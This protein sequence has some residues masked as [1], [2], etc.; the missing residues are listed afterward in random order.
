MSGQP[1][2]PE[3]ETVMDASARRPGRAKR[4]PVSERLKARV[5]GWYRPQLQWAGTMLAFA[6]FAVLIAYLRPAGRPGPWAW[7]AAPLGILMA[8]GVEY[9]THRFPMHKRSK[10]LDRFFRR[11]TLLHHRYF[12]HTHLEMNSRR[13]GYFV[14]ANLH[15]ASVA[16][17]LM[18]GAYFAMRGLVGVHF[19]SVATLAMVGYGMFAETMHVAYHM[20]EARQRSWPLRSRAFQYLRELHR[21]HHNPKAMTTYNFA[22]G[23]PIWDLICGTYRPPENTEPT[24]EVIAATSHGDL[25]L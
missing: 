18:L 21:D 16:V 9:V 15:V 3:M 4:D 11:H 20:S 22:I 6:A 10:T 1:R 7:L 5:P 12:D 19:A 23:L 13:D 17:L 8:S 14:L 24:P 2:W 25:R